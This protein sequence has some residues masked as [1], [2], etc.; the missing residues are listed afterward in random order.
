M[1]TSAFIQEAIAH[2]DHLPLDALDAQVHSLIAQHEQFN[3][4]ECIVLYAGTNTMN[5]RA[6]A[7][8]ASS[9]GSRPSLGHP[10]EKYNKGMQHAEQIELICM[11]LLR[12]LFKANYVE[13]RTP[14]GSLANLYACMA[15][16]QPGDAIPGIQ[17]R[18]RRPSD[19]SRQ[20][21]GR[22]IRP[23]GARHALR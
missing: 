15:T 12:S 6:R 2:Y 5:P 20:R 21:R 3:D 17:R 19:P 1:T 10:G 9:L 14:S 23:Q 4:R 8:L 18:G 13:H 22:A 11:A 16:C 7:L